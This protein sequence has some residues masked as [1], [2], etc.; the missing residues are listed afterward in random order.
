MKIPIIRCI[1]FCLLSASS[2][3]EEPIPEPVVFA[4]LANAA[5]VSWMN[6]DRVKGFCGALHNHLEA[7]GYR[8]E[9]LLLHSVA[10]RFGA[11]AQK[12]A[13]R[14]GIECGPDSKTRERVNA[15][16]DP[17]GTFSGEFSVPFARTS[18]KLLIKQSAVNKL[19][20]SD[21]LNS[22][23]N[24]RIGVLAAPPAQPGE[25]KTNGRCTLAATANA[26]TVVTTSLIAYVLHNAQIFECQD[27]NS[28]L[29]A[30]CSGDIDAYSSDEV[31]LHSMHQ[32]LTCQQHKSEHYTIYPPL[33]ADGFSQEEYGVTLYNLPSVALK[34]AVNDW[35]TSPE[36]QAEAAKLQPQL[37]PLEQEMRSLIRNGNLAGEQARR[38]QLQW[39]RQVMQFTII[40]LCLALM[41]SLVVL[42]KA[43][44]IASNAAAGSST[45]TGSNTEEGNDRGDNTQ[46]NKNAKML[47]EEQF[48]IAVRRTDGLTEIKTMD[49]LK[50]KHK[51]EHKPHRVN[52]QMKVI[53]EIYGV[54]GDENEKLREYLQRD[55]PEKFAEYEKSKLAEPEQRSQQSAPPSDND[56]DFPPT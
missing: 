50:D 11:F 48:D 54:R 24:L 27:R 10:E 4:Y 7:K 16:H 1:T 34:K 18:T 21:E 31:I 6:H 35:I 8:L 25:N 55:F 2:I 17:A 51:L 40:A 29:T 46:A 49:E 9:I 36:G 32:E 44:R 53:R 23:E 45:D 42:A 20:T 28:A 15:L 26:N 39:E 37:S 47:T 5:P 13:G 3:A 30:L 19:H 52:N 41:A 22:A 38:D 14:P 12:L 56:E 43:K 33:Y